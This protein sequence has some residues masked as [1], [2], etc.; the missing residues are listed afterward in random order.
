MFS[1]FI[2]FI[3]VC[4]FCSAFAQQEAPTA[5]LAAGVQTKQVSLKEEEL[6]S[7]LVGKKVSYQTSRGMSC[8]L[9]VHTDKTVSDYCGPHSDQGT[10]LIKDSPTGKSKLFCRNYPREGEKC[11][12]VVKEENGVYYFGLTR[13]TQSKITKIDPL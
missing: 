10:W 9:D 7:L 5:V 6:V 12:T 8:R 2:T 4:F 11:T 13:S 3:L 1:K